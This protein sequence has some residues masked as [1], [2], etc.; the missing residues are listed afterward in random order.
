MITRDFFEKAELLCVPLLERVER[1]L[2]V[3]ASLRSMVI[4]QI[5][6]K[7]KALYGF[8]TGT[9]LGLN[10]GVGRQRPRNSVGSFGNPHRRRAIS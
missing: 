9:R 10:L 6:E 3:Q 4:I 5:N 2:V 8:Q 1:R 7:R